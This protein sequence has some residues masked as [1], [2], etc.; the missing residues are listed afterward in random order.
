MALDSDSKKTLR[1]KVEDADLALALKKRAAGDVGWADAH[2]ELSEAL[3]ALADAED[4]DDVALNH[5]QE[6][7]D[8][9]E[10][11]L[12]VFTREQHF[13]RWGAV[14][15]SYVR[16]LRNFALREGGQVATLR[17]KRS[18]ALLDDVYLALPDDKGAI[19]RALVS[20][21]KGHVYRALADTDLLRARVIHLADAVR[22]F[23]SAAA[24]MREKENFYYWSLAV[25]ACA[26]A[27]AELARMQ[28]PDDARKSFQKAIAGFETACAYEHGKDRPQDWSYL[29][30][31]MGRALVQLSVLDERKRF[32]LLEQALKSFQDAKASFKDSNGDIALVRLQN[33]TAMTLSLLAQHPKS[34]NP[35]ALLEQSIELY[36]GSIDIL[37]D[38]NDPIATAVVYGN[39]GKDLTQLANLSAMPAQSLKRRYE[40][41]A[42][43]R[44]AIGDELRHTRPLDWLSYF[45]ELGAALQAA[46]NLEEP[47]KKHDL[48]LEAIK[49]YNE[50]LKTISE[51]QHADLIAKLMQWRGL[52]RAHLGEGDQSHHGLTQ[53][54]QAELDFRMIL[55][56]L[57]PQRNKQDL[58]RLH[59]NLAHLLYAMARRSDSE[60]PLA[61]LQSALEAIETALSL[62]QPDASCDD[63]EHVAAL[64]HQALILW[65]MGS[66]GNVMEAFPKAQSIYERL[67]LIPLLKDN[68]ANLQ[69]LMNNYALMLRDWADKEKPAK[70]K[71]YLETSRNL[72]QEMRAYALRQ[73]DEKSV[74]QIDNDI[75]MV[76]DRERAL[77]P[78]RFWQIWPFRRQ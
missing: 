35:E 54:K 72:L 68:P 69:R 25:S 74:V 57:D 76:D 44:K 41:I 46:A 29:K 32:D 56:K 6:S 58:I 42:A 40:A 9:F 64:S 47:D 14:V 24:I 21:E 10:K 52:A 59:T 16:C 39:F 20:T 73:D 43:L 31:E 18:I 19:D 4:N 48:F 63:D 27:A 45:V 5:Y 65:R 61:L 53:L 17:L 34:K 12:Q 7:A 62:M 49:L 3:M 51:P 71:A 67:L 36:Q 30:F 33:E 60:D 50:A 11:A 55:P 28:K 23:D 75:R 38:K 15:V 37:G 78:K 77:K 8:G 13:A 1:Q 70:A 26:L 66:F 22:A 2:I